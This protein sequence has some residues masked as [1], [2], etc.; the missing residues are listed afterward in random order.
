MVRWIFRLLA[1]ALSGAYL[2]SAWTIHQANRAF[3]ATPP[4]IAAAEVSNVTEL[5]ATE[6]SFFLPLLQHSSHR[7]TVSFRSSRFGSVVGPKAI[8]ESVVADLSAKQPV[9]VQYMPDNPVQ[10]K[11]RGTEESPVRPTFIG[12]GILVAALLLTWVRSKH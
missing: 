1:L 12:L 7:A 5:A 11:F 9:F 6:R 10:Y 3:N 2:W 8:P 4:S